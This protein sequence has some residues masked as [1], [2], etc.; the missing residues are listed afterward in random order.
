LKILLGHKEYSA[1]NTAIT[2][3]TDISYEAA[4]ISA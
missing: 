3:E 1:Y 4:G 2:D